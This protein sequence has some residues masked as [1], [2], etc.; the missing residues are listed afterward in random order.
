MVEAV[1]L[2]QGKGGEFKVKMYVWL[3]SVFG[4][5]RLH[6]FV[7][8]SKCDTLRLFSLRSG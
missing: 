1:D 7:F 4:K 5:E 8:L 3:V 2:R 6:N